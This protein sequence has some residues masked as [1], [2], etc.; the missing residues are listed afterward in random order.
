MGIPD[1]QL[2]SENLLYRGKPTQ[3]RSLRLYE[4]SG[5]R[6]RL[7]GSSTGFAEVRSQSRGDLAR[8]SMR[9]F[10]LCLLG[11][12]AHTTSQAAGG[13]ISFTGAAL[14]LL[15]LPALCSI[16]LL[17]VIVGNPSLRRRLQKTVKLFLAYI[18]GTILV[19][20]GVFQGV[21]F[22]PLAGLVP[23]LLFLAPW[24]AFLALY[25]SYTKAK[26]SGP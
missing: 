9:A 8:S 16:V 5:D 4:R 19:C 12:G 17:I 7:N 10:L 2:A 13:S 21:L 23:V 3:S 6:D 24:P 15:H 25:K 26:Q 20:A 1:Y 18:L 22:K 11:I 14:A